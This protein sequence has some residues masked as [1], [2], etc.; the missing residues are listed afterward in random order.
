MNI[1]TITKTLIEAGIEPN[2]AAKEVKM[3]KEKPTKKQLY[4]YD[5][6][7]KKYS[8]EK[9]NVEELSKLD[10]RDEIERILNEHSDD[11]KN[12]D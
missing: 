9:K 1:Q 11:Y 4:Y 12:V 5:R 2:E 10:L 3:S 6:L 7:C 8:L